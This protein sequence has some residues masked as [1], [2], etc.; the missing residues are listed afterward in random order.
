MGHT[1]AAHGSRQA[2]L[3]RP[4]RC[5]ASR[6]E[7]GPLPRWKGLSGLSGVVTQHLEMAHVLSASRPTLAQ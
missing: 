4:P 1:L 7:G 5:L 6:A 3:E 2:H